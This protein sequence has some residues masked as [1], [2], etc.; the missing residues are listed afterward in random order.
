MR[1]VNDEDATDAA[2]LPAEFTARNFTV[3][4][5]PFVP[6]IVTGDVVT[7]GESAYQ[8]PEPLS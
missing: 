2:P 3:Y 8:L 4:S 6:A 7:A 1:G 5:T